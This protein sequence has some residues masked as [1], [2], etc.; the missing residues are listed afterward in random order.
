MSKHS[1]ISKKTANSLIMS[2]FV[3]LIAVSLYFT[4]RHYQWKKPPWSPEINAVLFMAGDNRGELEKVLKHYSRNPADSLKLRAAEFLIAN[5]PGKYSQEYDAPLENVVA[6]YMRRDD[7]EDRKAVN[8]AYGL[9]KRTVRED[10]K[11]ITGDYLIS[12][13]ELS[14]KVWNEQPWGRDVPFDVFCEE[15]LP[16]RVALEPLENWRGKILSTYTKHNSFF[17]EH[18]KTTSTDACIRINSQLPRLQIEQMPQSMTYSMIMTTSRGTCEEMTALATFVMRALGIPVS[19]DFITSWPYRNIGHTWNSVYDRGIRISFM[20]TEAN[21]G[22]SHHGSRMPSSKVY[23]KTYSMQKNV[24]AGDLNIPPTLRQMCI[25]DVTCEYVPLPPVPKVLR[26]LDLALQSCEGWKSVKIPVRY[27]SPNNTGH[28]YLAAIG[29]DNTWNTTGYGR[30]DSKTVDFGAVGHNVL[31]LPVYHENNT[32]TPVNY[33]FMVN[34]NDSVRIFEPDEDDYRK[35]GMSKI[36]P[37]DDEYSERMTGGVFEGANKSD[38]SDAVTLYTVHEASGEHFNT[39]IIRNPSRFRYV[40]YVS[41]IGSYCYVAEI[42]FYSDRGERLGGEPTGLPGSR[43]NSSMTFDMTLDGDISTYH[44]APLSDNSWVGLDFGEPKRTGKIQYLPRNSGNGIYEGHT[45]ELFYWKDKKWQ[46]LE[47]QKA[48][49][50][51]LFFKA[52]TNA[53]LFIKN[54][55]ANKSGKCFVLNKS[56]EQEWL[57]IYRRGS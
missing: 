19:Q 54:I 6:A 28:V 13:I 29:G 1:K 43:R 42:I 11:Y 34:S 22:I 51:H 3:L 52:P 17:R 38:F 2:A 41:P 4:W 36:F 10:V 12:N 35:F 23:R 30:S 24:Y 50:S 9:G 33:P 8:E 45:Y 37:E 5:M 47:Q 40:R 14:F 56:G 18:P 31:H 49:T 21:P 20:G 15:I 48:E 16:Y 46:F 53:V 25:R 57:Y 27:P 55:T 44:D 32:Q 7:V 39:A 26:P